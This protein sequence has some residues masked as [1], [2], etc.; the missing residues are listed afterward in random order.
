LLLLFSE[1]VVSIIKERVLS[2]NYDVKLEGSD[3]EDFPCLEIAFDSHEQ[4]PRKPARKQRTTEVTA[5][6]HTRLSNNANIVYNQTQCSRYYIHR[7][8]TTALLHHSTLDCAPSL[9]IVLFY[10][11]IF[12]FFF[13]VFL[14]VNF[15]SLQLVGLAILLSPMLLLLVLPFSPSP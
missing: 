13:F 11:V 15:F 3:A 2:L 10:V 12:F 5:I 8:S 1:G 4:K 14:F 9:I 6:A 7:R